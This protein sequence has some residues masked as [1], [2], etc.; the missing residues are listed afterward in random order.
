MS[1]QQ[2]KLNFIENVLPK[3]IID[4]NEELKNHSVVK[5]SAKANSQLD[6]FMAAIYSVDLELKNADGG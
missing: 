6:G 5:C 2:R 3:L 1:E 4:R